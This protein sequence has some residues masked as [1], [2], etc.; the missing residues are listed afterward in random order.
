M[1]LPLVI[2]EA[3]LLK[4]NWCRVF[5]DG[6]ARSEDAELRVFGIVDT[7]L[8]ACNF[9]CAILASVDEDCGFCWPRFDRAVFELL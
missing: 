2:F 5:Y 7:Q 4:F 8:M 6:F 1:V 3:V 9:E